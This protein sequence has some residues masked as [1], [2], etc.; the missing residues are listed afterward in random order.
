MELAFI[1]AEKIFEMFLIL[2]IGAAAYRAGF[3]DRETSKKMS[4]ILLNVISPCVIIMSYQIEFQKDLLLELA[5]TA[6][7][8]AVSFLMAIII[9]QL[10]I[11]KKGNPDTEVERLSVVYSNCGF[12]GIPL[13]NGILGAKG[14]F[15]MSAYITVF[16][17]LIWSHGVMTMNGKAGSFAEIAKN[18]MRSSTI[19]IGIG[20]VFFINR[21]HLPEVIAAPLSMVGDMNTPVAMMISGINLAESNFL[22]S[23][24]NSRIYLI[25]GIKLMVIPLMTLI[26]LLLCKAERTIAITILTAAACPSGAMGTMFALEYNKNSGYASKLFTITTVLSLFTIPAIM[27]IS[28]EWI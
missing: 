13:I 24:K 26:M 7:L 9:S 10:V 1:T 14:V 5:V 23:L 8:S 15:L 20:I 18:F 12:I 3:A 22:S 19:A 4:A 25:S 11:R 17:I 2:L 16:N 28:G 6:L 27:L 21:L